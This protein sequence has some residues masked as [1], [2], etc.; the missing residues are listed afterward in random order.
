MGYLCEELNP[1]F[2]SPAHTNSILTAIVDGMQPAR[3]LEMQVAAV[4]AMKNSLEFAEHN[5][6]NAEERNMIMQVICQAT[7]T[8]GDAAVTVRQGAFECIATIAATYYEKLPAYMDALYQLTTTAISSDNPI[9]GMQAIEF[10][11]SICEEVCSAISHTSFHNSCCLCQFRKLS[12]LKSCR[13]I[14]L[15]LKVQILSIFEFVRALLRSPSY[16]DLA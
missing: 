2:V 14:L 10:W 16:V 1:E 5:F 12:W 4:K 6:E 11:S 8:E 7:Q 9:V 15:Q 3:S 13:M